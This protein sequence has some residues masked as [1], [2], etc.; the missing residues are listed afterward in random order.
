M[1]FDYLKTE[2][3]M[4]NPYSDRLIF[5]NNVGYLR[6]TNIPAETILQLIGKGYP[7]DYVLNEFPELQI[8]DVYACLWYDR[9]FDPDWDKNDE[10]LILLLARS[11]YSRLRPETNLTR[12]ELRKSVYQHFGWNEKL[13][14]RL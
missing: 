11:A 5:R 2:N 7:I 12:E 10:F 6:E 3:R 9:D 8:E 1:G 13:Q 4:Q 14:T